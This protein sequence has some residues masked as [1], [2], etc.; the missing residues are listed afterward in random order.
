M[1]L[2]SLFSPRRV[3][4]LGIC[5]LASIHS[6]GQPDFPRTPEQAKLVYSDL[7]HFMDAY[8]ALQTS[9]DTVA[10]LQTLYFEKGS[11]GL[12]EFVQRHQLTPELLKDALA[13]APERYALLPAFME[14][15]NA[16]E[17]DYAALM[18][19]FSEV[20]PNAMYPP[21]Y[22]LV[23]ANRGIGQASQAGQLITVTR[24]LDKPE[25][26]RQL[27]VH[28]LSHF[29]Q[30]MAM[31]GQQYQALYS[32]P[33]NMLGLCLREGG[34]EFITSLVLGVITQ[35]KALEFIHQN[36]NQLKQRF[37]EDLAQQEK[38]YWLWDS[39]EQEE[40]PKL[41]GYAMGYKICSAYYEQAADKPA[42]LQ[43]VL[44]MKDPEAFTA[45]SGYLSR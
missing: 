4:Y 24:V 39:I 20:M 16:T 22:L 40:H 28:E 7:E 43:E 25:K 6:F 11:P 29:Q 13:K 3:F 18:S 5:L 17:A 1:S 45:A 26:F 34:A 44:L 8:R 27:M 41:L 21:T 2:T 15:I 42:A 30:A 35:N 9:Q 32:A 37:A 31:G 33:N 38:G 23:G 36:E 19:Q 14:K 10:V 12:K